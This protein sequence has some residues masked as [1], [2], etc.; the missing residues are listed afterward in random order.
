[1]K[2]LDRKVL[3][4][5]RL[6]WSQAL[7]I[8][9]VVASGIGGFIAC[10]SAVD[11]LALARDD[12]YAAGHFADVFAAVKRAP[13]TLAQRL[14]EVPGIVDVQTTV[15]SGA[16]VTLPTTPD[17][18]IGQI[19]GLDA[20]HAPRLN[21]ITLRSGRRPEAGT[22]AGGELEALVSE[23]FANAH[24]LKVG[25]QVSA[26][27]NG[28]YQR[29]NRARMFVAMWAEG[30]NEAMSMT[31]HPDLQ[32]CPG[33]LV[34]PMMTRALDGAIV[35]DPSNLIEAGIFRGGKYAA[36]WAL[37]LKDPIWLGKEEKWRDWIKSFGVHDGLL[38]SH[39]YGCDSPATREFY[40]H[41]MT[42]A[43]RPAKVSSY[44]SDVVS[45]RSVRDVF[46]ELMPLIDG[47]PASQDQVTTTD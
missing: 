21:L 28:D 44:Y 47:P 35:G 23:G 46:P 16:R 20:R 45:F 39:R 41:L 7:T 32:D 5:L 14:R 36:S 31:F 37:M 29:L 9:L 33:Y 43:S 4:D 27:M 2:A 34:N 15:E 24:G 38:L 3:R 42:F 22:R 13:D 19:I 12:F 26:L 6:L 8:A 25:S 10:L 30:V 11:S 17:P 1:V 18:V 40:A